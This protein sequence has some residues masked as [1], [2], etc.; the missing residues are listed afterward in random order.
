MG[1]GMLLA[2]GNND[3]TAFNALWAFYQ[4]SY[5]PNNLMNWDLTACGT[6]SGT[7]YAATD[8]DE[9]VAM[10]L[11]Q[12]DCTWGGYTAAATKQITA[13]KAHGAS[14]VATPW[15]LQPGDAVNNGGKG[16]GIVDPSY[17]A[18]GYWH[19]WAKYTN[20][21][22]WNTLA[23]NAYTMLAAYQTAT[24]NLVPHNLVPDWGNT[25]GTVAYGSTYYTT[26][27]EPRGVWRSTMR[28]SAIP[29]PRPFSP[30][31]P[32]TSTA[33]GVWR[34]YPSIR[35]APSWAPSPCQALR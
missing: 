26:R 35:T 8:A 1:Y 6:S 34:A 2:V 19:A 23:D 13:I 12:A 16:A 7:Q 31:S 28:G 33:K 20:D 29:A 5:D 18:I 9:D 3:Q 22:S 25:D 11:V 27:V 21:T 4:A 32:R 15:Y 10:A 30:T 17:F 14:E 24:N